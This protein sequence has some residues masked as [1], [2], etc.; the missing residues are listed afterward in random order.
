MSPKERSRDADEEVLKK[1]KNKKRLLSDKIEQVRV[2]ENARKHTVCPEA[3]KRLPDSSG[4]T[5]S[6]QK[7]GAPFDVKR[8]C[9]PFAGTRNGR[10]GKAKREHPDFVGFG[11]IR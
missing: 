7:G 11:I 5:R 9:N 10:K 8:R 4:Q 3:C 2:G 1:T 6:E